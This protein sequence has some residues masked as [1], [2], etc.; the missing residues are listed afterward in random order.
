MSRIFLLSSN[1]AYDPYPVYPLGMA[2]VAA[3][4]V[5]AGH[6]VCQFDHL[7]EGSS[8]DKLRDS[9]RA[10]APDVV[11]LSL[12]N[13]DNVDSFSG[14]AGWYLDIAR[15]L[16]RVLREGTQS[17]IM[18]GGPAFS[19]MP[20]EILEYIEADYGVVGEGE[21][22][23]CNLV[24]ALS[25][26]RPREKLHRAQNLLSG[27]EIPSPLMNNAIASFYAGASGML[28]LQTKRGC[29]HGCEYCA[30]PRLEGSAC[31]CREPRAV[32]NDLARMRRDYGVTNFFFA[33][34]VFNDEGG[35]YLELAEALCQESLNIQWC[36]FFRPK[37]LGC[38]EISLLKRSG[39]Y[40]AE[41]GTDAVTDMTLNSLRKG[42]SFSDVLKVTKAFQESQVPCAHYVMFGGPGETEDTVNEGFGNINRLGSCVIFAFSGIR[43]LPGTEIHTRA[44]A[45][46][47]LPEIPSLL[48]PVYYFSPTIDRQTLN[49]AV[50]RAFH[51]FRTRIFPPSEGRKRLAVLHDFGFRGILWDKLTSP[52]SA[53]RK[54]AP[55]GC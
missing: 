20:E 6:D 4:L 27:S 13:I 9:V 35:H 40:A 14:E 42:Y 34:A 18:V 12:R 11:G 8:Q 16:V 32:A 37:G 29:P 38:K 15:R 49:E 19:L 39:L 25:F 22:V 3:A 23:A 2:A 36:A 31:R 28:G 47:L 50:A 46:G 52:R 10:F 1:V 17:P 7:S 53:T 54:R 21:Q 43:I 45:E 24:E 26:G 51:G 55:R 48:R 5:A 44:L 41:L 30:Y 33:D